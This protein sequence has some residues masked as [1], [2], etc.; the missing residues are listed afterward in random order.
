MWGKK[1]AKEALD[2]SITTF[3]VEKQLEKLQKPQLQN[4]R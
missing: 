1:S 2:V 3:K 4:L